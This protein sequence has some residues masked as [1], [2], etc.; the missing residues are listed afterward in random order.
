MSYL[1][2]FCL[3]VI[4]GVGVGQQLGCAPQRKV[5]QEDPYSKVVMGK[6]SS[7]ELLQNYGTPV[8]AYRSQSRPQAVVNQ[9]S[10]NQTFQS[11]NGLVVAHFRDPVSGEDRDERSLQYWL[12]LWRGL[13]TVYEEL[14]GSRG[15]H[16]DALF[17]LKET[18]KKSAVIYDPRKKEVIRV[19]QYGN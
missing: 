7:E 9:F 14:P 17:I 4:L 12:H 2:L 3:G 6:T 11:E 8:R 15:P 5:P 1:N 10:K 18:S 19:L 16:G 13:N